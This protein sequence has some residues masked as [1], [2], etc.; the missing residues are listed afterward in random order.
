MRPPETPP[1]ETPQLPAHVLFVESRYRPLLN[2]NDP[3]LSSDYMEK[4]CIESRH[5]NF[6]TG[7]PFITKTGVTDESSE[8]FTQPYSWEAMDRAIVENKPWMDSSDDLD[9][10]HLEWDPDLHA[11]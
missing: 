3:Y 8:L 1:P 4:Y 7:R 9:V 10:H 5:M 6:Y 2:S 11:W